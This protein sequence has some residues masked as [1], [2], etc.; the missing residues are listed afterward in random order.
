M[1]NETWTAKELFAGFDAAPSFIDELERLG[2]LSVR[3]RDENGAS[4]YGPESKEQ[5]AQVIP[6]LELG[7]Q[8]KDIAAIAKKVG[9][10]TT[11]RRRFS[12]PPTFIRLGELA[13]R[14][15][16][17]LSQLE[18]WQRKGLLRPGMESEGGE[19]FFSTAAVQVVQ[20]LKDFKEFG[21]S[22]DQLSE[23]TELGRQVDRVID[24]L[25]A[26]ADTLDPVA[27]ASQVADATALIDRLRKR[28][29]R[30]QTGVR[31]W[32]KLVGAYDKRLERL[33][34]RFRVE[35]KRPRRRKRI[36]VRT[37]RRRLEPEG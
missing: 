18:E 23:W 9:L 15:G 16:V 28:L 3:G 37:R 6:L 14:S 20:A 12:A 2:L 33:R 17:A 26:E 32:D 24:R 36:R 34:K 29:E 27:G 30:L 10:P 5:L 8:P 31:R 21:L 35:G 7:Y 1:G 19:P 11:R 22:H 4:L 13:Q 25:Y